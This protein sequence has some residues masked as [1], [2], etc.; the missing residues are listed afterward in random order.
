MLIMGNAV[1]PMVVDVDVIEAD[2][3]VIIMVAP[4]PT[5]GTPPGLF[6]RSQPASVAESEAKPHPPIIGEARAESVGAWAAHPVTSDIWRVGPPRAVNHD[7]VRADLGA[8]VSRRVT[9]VH[10]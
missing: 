9:V 2:M 10:H 6:P 5:V 7:V 3:I 1:V 8:E 4:S